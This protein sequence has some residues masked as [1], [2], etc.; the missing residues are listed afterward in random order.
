MPHQLTLFFIALIFYTRLPIPSWVEYD[1]AYLPRSSRYLPLV[2]FFV[3]GIGALVFWLSHWL[4]PVSIA[5]LLSIIAT[6]LVTGAFHEDGLADSCDGFGGGWSTEQ[7]LTIMKDSRVGTFGMVGLSLMLGLKFVTL[8]EISPPLL[9]SIIIAGHTISRLMAVS[10]L[11]SHDYVRPQ[12][13]S[14]AQAHAQRMAGSELLIAVLLGL[15]PLLFLSLSFI[16]LLIPLIV[17]RQ[18]LGRYFVKRLGGFTGDCL[19]A[20]QQL[21]EVVFYLGCVVVS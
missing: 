12:A 11:Y 14:K 3:G 21:T 10:F 18:L 4:W 15:F 19:G 13:Q 9:P 6:V 17:V 20:T 16:L 1:S 8:H 2:G 7:I 5:V